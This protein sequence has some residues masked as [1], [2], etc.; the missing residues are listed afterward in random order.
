M[1]PRRIRLKGFLS[2]R[3]EQQ[4]DFTEANLWMLSGANGSGKS[5]IFDAV[6][7]ALYGQHRG[8]ARGWTDLIY[9]SADSLLVEFEFE[10]E[11][12]TYRIRRTVSRK[13][14]RSTQQIWEWE[15]NE[16]KP[17]SDTQNREGF[18]RWIQNRI[19]LDFEAFT[20]SVLL[21]QGRAEK[22]LDGTP[23]ER[24][25]VLA[26]I[27]D[28]SRYQRLYDLAD[29]ERKR[30]KEQIDNLRLQ[31]EALPEVRPEE[32]AEAKKVLE[33]GQRE[34]DAAIRRGQ[35]LAALRVQAENHAKL[36]QKRAATQHRLVEMKSLLE[37]R[38]SITRAWER[39]QLLTRV[40]PLVETIIRNRVDIKSAQDREM[41]L[42]K[43]V[44]ELERQKRE[45]SSDQDVWSRTLAEIQSEIQ[46][47]STQLDEKEQE[48]TRLSDPLD[49]VRRLNVYLEVK[50][51]LQADLNSIPRDL[52]QSL[53]DAQT[54]L[55]E[56]GRIEQSLPA[57]RHFAEARERL[58]CKIAEIDKLRHEAKGIEKRKQEAQTSAEQARTVA[59]QAERDVQNCREHV[60]SQQA[61]KDQTEKALQE[62]DTL[63]GA[64]TC[65]LCGQPL[66]PQ[67]YEAERSARQQALLQAESEWQSARE[68]LTEALSRHEQA[69]RDFRQ[70]ESRLRDVIEQHQDLGANLKIAENE[71]ERCRENC[72]LFYGSLPESYRQ[73]ICETAP[74]DWTATIFPS[75]SDL[76]HFVDRL[77]ELP[78][79]RRRHE[80]LRDL[81][82]RANRLHFEVEQNAEQIRSIEQRLPDE[83]SRITAKAAGLDQDIRVLKKCIED[84]RKAENDC[85][86]R[87]DELKMV[88]HQVEQKILEYRGQLAV[89]SQRIFQLQ[90]QVTEAIRQ[91]PDDWQ[92]R[93]DQIQLAEQSRLK[94]ELKNLD[95]QGVENQ[96]RQ[97]QQAVQE[98]ESFQRL[99]VEVESEIAAI[100]SDARRDPAE[101]D[102][103]IEGASRWQEQA[104]RA[105][106]KARDAWK[107]LE[108]QREQRVRWEQELSAREVDYRQAKTLAELLGRERLQRD[109]VRRA[110]RQI[111]SFANAVLDR[112]S[113]GTIYLRIVGEDQGDPADQ[114]L[115]LEAVNRATDQRPIA[116][117]YLSGSQK[118]RVAVSLALGMGQFAGQSHRPIESIIIDEGFGCLDRE[119]RQSMIQELHQLRGLLRCIILVSHQEEFASAFTDGYQFTLTQGST[120]VHRVRR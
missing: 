8:G 83:P 22:L 79:V 94:A 93:I 98:F 2:Y 53:T 4:L 52:T 17:I 74:V 102:Q 44:S 100:P 115:Q 19:G 76:T 82:V 65:R 33:E 12:R 116:V 108:S 43:Y 9:K 21:L 90:Q 112:L 3:D 54:E 103:E 88:T 32:I 58:R 113:G 119:G 25:E 106:E 20:S 55:A 57:L 86:D 35:E 37:Q 68:R 80:H 39:W 67:H 15:E 69:D 97:L 27:V 110:E 47:M 51:Q 105:V 101:I 91:L 84:I 38:E 66:T 104:A 99:M 30:I 75:D 87:I 61:L 7:F 42:A 13:Q 109:L 41:E 46:R 10:L 6:T 50:E 62:F 63:K 111:V 107:S 85:R 70:M 77:A 117:P 45:K 5:A 36:C 96:F 18:N 64:P 114:A 89:E 48:R 34:L 92:H 60:A 95:D 81:Q 59:A 11:G 71:A 14:G 118:F 16:W 72:R 56:I 40:I 1:I 49:L 31:L 26:K 78:N 73:E 24:A 28:L 120:I 23:K 29:A